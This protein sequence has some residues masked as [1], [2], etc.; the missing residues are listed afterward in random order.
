MVEELIETLWNVNMFQ[1]EY[2]AEL[3]QELI[4]TLWNV[5]SFKLIIF[6][7]SIRINRNIVEC[8]LCRPRP[9]YLLLCE[10]IET[11]WNV[12]FQPVYIRLS[13]V[14]ELIETLWNVNSFL[15]SLSPGSI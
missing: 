14:L 13:A 3:L 1:I 5:N 11:L 8:K 6:N 10:L 12:N 7:T 9:C 2:E 15:K 4:E